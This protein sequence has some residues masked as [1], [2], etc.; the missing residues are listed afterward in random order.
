MPHRLRGSAKDKRSSFSEE[1][2]AKR[3]YSSAASPPYL[4]SEQT[5]FGSFFQKRTCFLS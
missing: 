4:A 5:C 1:K 3:L 2:E